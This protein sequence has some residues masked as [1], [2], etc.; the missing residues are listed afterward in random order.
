MRILQINEKQGIVKVKVESEEDL[1]IL[2]TTI[3][4]DDIVYARTTREI[5]ADSTFGRGSSRRCL[6]YTSPSPRD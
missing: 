5:K 6:L 4:K 1:W 3:I 2:Y